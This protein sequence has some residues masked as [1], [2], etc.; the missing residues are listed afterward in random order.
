MDLENGP[1][2]DYSKLIFQ[3]PC[4]TSMIMGGRVYDISW[5]MI[6]CCCFVWTW[7]EHLFGWMGPMPPP[8]HIV[9][10]F[11]HSEQGW[12]AAFFQ[13]SHSFFHAVVG[14]CWASLISYTTSNDFNVDNKQKQTHTNTQINIQ[15]SRNWRGGKNIPRAASNA[16]LYEF[17]DEL[18]ELL[19]ECMFGTPSRK[20][21]TQ[22]EMP[23]RNGRKGWSGRY[24][25]WLERVRYRRNPQGW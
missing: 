9:R 10:F 24:S 8:R 17:C 2:G 23:T 5:Y 13:P 6:S 22:T 20:E 3:G 15:S 11:K 14:N 7:I 4:S 19:Q 1:L 25:D 16:G 21:R 12:N 18:Y